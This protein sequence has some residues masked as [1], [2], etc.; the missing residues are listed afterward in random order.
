[1]FLVLGLLYNGVFIEEYIW[2][3]I[4]GSPYGLLAHAKTVIAESPDIKNVLVYNDIG[5]HDIKATGKYERRIYAAPM[6]ESFYKELFAGFTEYILYI[7]I[8]R[9]GDGNLF[10]NYFKSCETIYEETDR[11]IDS[12]ILK[13][14]PLK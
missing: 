13:C 1:M 7:N 4:N 3:N 14:T 12:K 11:Y 5:G 6:F 8:P 9:V 10:S 2:G